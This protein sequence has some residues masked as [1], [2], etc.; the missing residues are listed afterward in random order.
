MTKIALGTVQFGLDYGIANEVG[1]VKS[2]E[3]QQI[4]FEAK[5]NKIDM[6]DTAIAYGTSEVVLGGAGIDGFRV[7]TKLPALPTDQSDIGHWVRDHVNLSLKR[8]KQETLHAL[9]LHRAQ[10]LLGI[11]GAQLIQA[12][13]H[14]K[15]A[16]IRYLKAQIAILQDTVLQL[17]LGSVGFQKKLHYADIRPASQSMA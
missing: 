13:R 4:L 14:L 1:Q 16:G 2:A 3:V 7:V 8:L 10:D 15:S 9:L 17:F 6:L 5:K 12:L 11:G